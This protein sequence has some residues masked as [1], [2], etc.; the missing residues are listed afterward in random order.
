MSELPHESR[1]GIPVV[2]SYPNN[3]FILNPSYDPVAA[4][5]TTEQLLTG[6][7]PVIDQT[8][9][10]EF[11]RLVPPLHDCHD[12]VKNFF[13]IKKIFAFHY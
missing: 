7:K 8:Y 10:P 3:K 1:S 6:S 2:I 13:S 12:E 5:K 11:I 9:R 4:K